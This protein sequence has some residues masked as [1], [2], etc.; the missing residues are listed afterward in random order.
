[1][2]KTIAAAL[3]ALTFASG[4]AVV[5]A[6]A[7]IAAPAGMQTPATSAL[8]LAQWHPRHR[9]HYR[10]PPPPRPH[11]YRGHRHWRGPGPGAAAGLAAGAIIGGAIA[12][13][14]AQEGRAAAVANEAWLRHCES[15]YK[16]FDPATGTY[17]G[18]DGVRHY[19]Q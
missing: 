15:K 9:D 4:T 7:E 5:P 19:C 14:R 18:Y 8:Q 1:M 3:A 11:Y 16:S 12:A 10:R 6:S 2:R 17:L 13:Q